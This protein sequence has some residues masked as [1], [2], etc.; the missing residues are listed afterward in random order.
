MSASIDLLA[1]GTIQNKSSKDFPA[2]FKTGI[3]SIDYLGT[4]SV[5]GEASRD[6]VSKLEVRYPDSKDYLATFFCVYPASKDL[7]AKAIIRK[8]SLAPNLLAKVFV[9]RSAGKEPADQ[10]ITKTAYTL[11]EETIKTTT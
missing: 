2:F 1:T 9:Y 10:G 5:Q 7:L 4:L 6:L 3:G 8:R 11:Q